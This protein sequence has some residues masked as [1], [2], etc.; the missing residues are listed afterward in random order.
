MVP[1]DLQ[2]PTIIE[3]ESGSLLSAAFRY[4]RLSQTPDHWYLL[5]WDSIDLLL[6]A[7]QTD[8]A[9]LSLHRLLTSGPLF[10]DQV[11]RGMKAIRKK[12]QIIDCLVARVHAVVDMNLS[13]A[14]TIDV[15]SRCALAL[16]P[17][18]Q[19]GVDSLVSAFETPMNSFPKAPKKTD[20]VFEL[21]L[22]ALIRVGRIGDNATRARLESEYGLNEI[23]RKASTDGL[24]EETVRLNQW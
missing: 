17:H 16:C 6:Q 9:R 24:R 19:Q 11:V 8:K 12:N 7:A 13:R 10:S 22:A 3:S 23:S 15:L 20:P 18:D 1:S 2:A 14:I 4:H 5:V 21:S